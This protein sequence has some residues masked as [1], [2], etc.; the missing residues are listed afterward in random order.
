MT[1][2]PGVWRTEQQRRPR[3]RRARSVPDPGRRAHATTTCA[4]GLSR[5]P[6]QRVCSFKS[7]PARAGRARS[8]MDVPKGRHPP[9]GQGHRPSLEGTAVDH[10]DRRSS[11]SSAVSGS[12]ARVVRLVTWRRPGLDARSGA[13]P[14]GEVAY[15]RCR[16]SRLRRTRCPTGHCRPVERWED[17]PAA[18]AATFESRRWRAR[19]C[20]T[21]CCALDPAF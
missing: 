21:R 4:M 18:R 9:G 12:S 5:A 2:E 7:V 3:H 11:W 8:I 10:F 20:G 14:A 16:G 19:W 13:P 15:R 17:G 1:Y 6:V